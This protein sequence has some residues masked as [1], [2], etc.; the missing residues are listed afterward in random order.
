MK[1]EMKPVYSAA[2]FL[3]KGSLIKETPPGYFYFGTE[4][5][6]VDS[7]NYY[8]VLRGGRIIAE[9]IVSC[10]EGLCVKKK[11]TN[12]H[13][14]WGAPVYEELFEL[15]VV[16]SP[17]FYCSVSFLKPEDGL[18]FDRAFGR[19][20][21]AMTIRERIAIYTAEILDSMFE[22]ADPEEYPDFYKL[23]ES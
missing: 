4:P 9:I 17:S 3:L 21:D 5:S 8:W 2:C 1:Y 14:F 12:K 11:Y 10:D 15:E 19:P 20:R 22:Q 18:W 6:P 23:Q 7:E 16:H 13:E